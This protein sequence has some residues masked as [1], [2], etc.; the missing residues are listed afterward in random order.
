M[1]HPHLPLPE[2]PACASEVA[3]VPPLLVS[4][5]H[6]HR[7]WSQMAG[8]SPVSRVMATFIVVGERERGT[9]Q[10]RGHGLWVPRGL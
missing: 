5:C 9:V 8:A 1:F 2:A 10:L 4:L 6:G 3:G 7:H